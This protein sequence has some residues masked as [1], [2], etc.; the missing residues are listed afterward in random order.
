MLANVYVDAFNLYYG[1]LKGTPYRWLD[2]DAFCRQL[3]P[4]T[5]STASATSPRWWPVV[6]VMSGSRN[7]SRRTCGPFGPSR[8]SVHL[9]HYL[10]H[11]VRMPLAQPPKVGRQT[12]EVLRTE[13]KGRRGGEPA[14]AGSEE[15]GATADLL[16]AGSRVAAPAQS[17]STDP[18]GRQGNDPEAGGLVSG[19][20]AR[21]APRPAAEAARGM[22]SA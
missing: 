10:S 4:A 15:R 12:V 1:C 22:A 6:P 13:E 7:V 14:S 16:A 8:T 17:V 11:P 3:L 21:N 18:G 2:L 9:G 20:G 5:A 19:R